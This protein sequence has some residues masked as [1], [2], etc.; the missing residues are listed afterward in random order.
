VLADVVFHGAKVDADEC[1]L[2]EV[3]RPVGETIG[4]ALELLE[5]PTECGR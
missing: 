4:Q 1:K 5:G 2:L 3:F